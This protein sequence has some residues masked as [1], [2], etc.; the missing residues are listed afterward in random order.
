MNPV[1]VI[2]QEYCPPYWWNYLGGNMVTW[3]IPFIF[4]LMLAAA[5]MIIVRV[6]AE[7][8]NDVTYHD[9]DNW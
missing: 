1:L 5:I 7:I 2:A 9:E 8:G 6:F 4:S 3:L